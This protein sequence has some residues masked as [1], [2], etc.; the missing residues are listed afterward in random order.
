MWS[1]SGP[2]TQ[3]SR[4]EGA[5]LLADISG[6][7][8]FLQGV[9]DAHRDVIVEADEPPPAYTV[10]SQL[11]DTIV[12]TIGPTF[13]LAKF[14]GDAV[15]AV[16]DDGVADG[17]AVIGGLR[18]CYAAFRDRLAAAGVEWTCT[19]TACSMIGNLDLK[20]ILHHGTYVAQPIGGHEELLGPSVNLVHRLLKNHA[21][22]LVGPVPYALVTE[23]AVQA[24]GVPTDGM[25]G[26]E[27]AFADMP[28]V[29]VH[30]LVLTQPSP[31]VP[32]A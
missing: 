14:E 17:E 18:R 12:A 8:S 30:V 25:V 19:C 24:L 16:A 6:Y 28:P 32:G 3:A 22:E 5:L 20:F 15:F 21:R 10:L 1:M 13:R 11:L 4:R 29:R 26:T 9:A 31:A 23:P 27:E 7:T 2:T